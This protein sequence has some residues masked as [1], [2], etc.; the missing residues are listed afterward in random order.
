MPNVRG[1]VPPALGPSSAC[2]STS[3]GRR[4]CRTG[5][6][7]LPGIPAIRS[8]SSMGP[9]SGTAR[10]P[11]S[12]ISKMPDLAG[13]AEAVLDRG[14]DAQR[15][16]PVAVKGQDGVDQVLD[17][18]GPGQ[19]AV[20]G[21]VA[22]QDDGHPG[23]LGQPGQPVHTRPDL[24]QAPGRARELVVGDGLDGVDDHQGGLMAHDGGLDGHHIVPGQGQQVLGHRADPGGPA[25]DLGQG[26]LGGGQ[27]HLGAGGG[28]RGQDLEEQGG[29]ADARAARRPGSPSPATNPPPRTRSTSTTPVAIGR[30]SPPSTWRSETATAASDPRARAAGVRGAAVVSVF[31]CPQWGQRP[32]HWGA[33][34]SQAV[35]R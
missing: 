7:T 4:P 34:P 19:V 20:L 10:S 33:T 21:D 23:G 32:T 3:S 26:L 5:T 18:P 14:Q 6:T 15:M 1:R 35:Q 31:H 12:R 28:H 16:V 27:Q 13:G 22:D 17:G 8:P 29:L 30:A 9:G 2:T 11:S 24:G 25:A